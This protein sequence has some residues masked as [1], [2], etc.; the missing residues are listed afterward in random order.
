[1]IPRQQGGSDRGVPEG[2]LKE[3][4]DDATPVALKDGFGNQ[5]I[6]SGGGTGPAKPQQPVRQR[7]TGA[8][9]CPEEWAKMS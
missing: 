9:S 6:E 4:D 2:T 3:A 7:T 5:L 8:N 1:M